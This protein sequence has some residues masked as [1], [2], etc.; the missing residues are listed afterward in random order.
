MMANWE[1]DLFREITG[2]AAV[3]PPLAG[4]PSALK[5]FQKGA[6]IEQPVHRR[7]DYLTDTWCHLN[8]AR[9]TRPFTAPQLAS[10]QENFCYFCPGNEHSTPRDVTTGGDTLSF[11]EESW[12][13]RAFPNLYPW[14]TGHGNVVESPHHKV[15][16]KDIDEEEQVSALIAI[17][18]LCGNFEAKRLYPMVFKNQ[19]WGASTPHTHWQYGALPYLPKRVACELATAHA[20]AQKWSVNIFDAIIEAEKKKAERFVSE[21]EY[22]NIITP[23]APR[24]NY[25]TWLILKIPAPS[26]T[27]LDEEGIRSLAAAMTKLLRALY[28]QL[29]ID[30]LCMVIHQC[31]G[32][33]DYRLHLEVLPYKHWAGAERG[34]E[35]YAVEVTPEQAAEFLRKHLG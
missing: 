21:N 20:F 26:L 11:G 10:Q 35:E 14:L 33:P 18:R 28:Q 15:S 27:S 12:T 25:E 2:S 16:L 23:Y 17:Q 6:Q 5:Q 34:F 1:S 31:A 22:V 13:V 32:E 3:L 24:S 7:K 29:S 30:S 8:L 19:G 9:A 4:T